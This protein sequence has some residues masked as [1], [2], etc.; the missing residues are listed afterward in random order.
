MG[1][2]LHCSNGRPFLHSTVR[3]L[4]WSIMDF[5]S[6]VKSGRVILAEG[7]VVE[8]IRR[9]PRLELDPHVENA[10]LIYDAG[11]RAALERIYQE[12][13]DIGENAGLPMILLSPTWR[14][15]PE[16]LRAAGFRNT[17]DVNGDGVRFVSEI[18]KRRG[19]YARQ[20]YVGGL[21]GCRGDAYDPRDALSEE[22]AASFHRWQVDWLHAAGAD[23]LIA[24]T[25]PAAI[26]ASYCAPAA[27]YW[28]ALHCMSSSPA[29]MAPPTR[30]RWV[31]CAIARIRPYSPRRSPGRLPSLPECKRA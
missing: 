26:E 7:A 8:R 9:D 1:R 6:T 24:S 23:F 14:A 4:Q 29:L 12:Y 15:G 19:E 3:L 18:R 28:T 31:T 27:S 22:R 16:R 2:V 20:V 5:A 25:L 13:L 17:D 10:A 30:P 11:G 21:M